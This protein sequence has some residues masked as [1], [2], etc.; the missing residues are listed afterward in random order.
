M[1][2]VKEYVEENASVHDAY[3]VLEPLCIELLKELDYYG[4]YMC[5]GVVYS[6][7]PVVS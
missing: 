4:P 6:Y 1:R 3:P 5:P 2:V 7:G